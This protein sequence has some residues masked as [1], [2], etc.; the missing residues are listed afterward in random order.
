MSDID[1]IYICADQVKPGDFLSLD[2]DLFM[3]P[4]GEEFWLEYEYAVASRINPTDVP[5][6]EVPADGV[7][8]EFETGELCAF[9]KDH[10]ILHAL[11]PL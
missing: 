3:D 8:I 2:H 4:D 9:P 1:H 5:R 10:L 11:P 7:L 6:Y